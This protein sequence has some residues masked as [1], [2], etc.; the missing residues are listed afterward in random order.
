MWFE[1]AIAA[2][3]TACGFV[4]AG[5][6]SSFYTLVTDKPVKFSVELETFNGDIRILRVGDERI[7]ANC[8]RRKFSDHEFWVSKGIGT[9]IKRHRNTAGGEFVQPSDCSPH[10]PAVDGPYPQRSRQSVPGRRADWRR[11][12][13]HDG[14]P[15]YD[16]GSNAPFH[17]GSWLG[18]ITRAGTHTGDAPQAIQSL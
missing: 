15:V 13:A 5:I 14:E 18:A 8:N 16:G 2:Y 11:P 4:A 12:L 6:L 3:A 10:S 17:G 9:R 1:L 7:P